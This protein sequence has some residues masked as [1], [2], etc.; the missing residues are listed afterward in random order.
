MTYPASSSNGNGKRPASANNMDSRKKARKDDDSEP[1]S[2]VAEKEEVKAKPTHGSY[3]Y[4]I[5][6]WNSQSFQCLHGLQTSENEVC[7]CRTRA[8][9]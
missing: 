1:Q 9:M 7:R 4:F 2:P 5:S 6:Q 3:L 8:S